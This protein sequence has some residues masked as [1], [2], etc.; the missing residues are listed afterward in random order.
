[1]NSKSNSKTKMIIGNGIVVTRDAKNRVIEQ[2]AIY[3]E[4]SH[5]AAIGATDVIRQQYKDS[6]VTYVDAEGMLIM[7]GYIN[8][9]EHIYSAFAR[10]LSIPGKHPMN[11]LEILNDTWWHMDRHLTLE[12]TYDSAAAT[13]LESIRNGVTFVSDHHAGYGSITGSLE[14]IAR[15]ADELGVRTCLAYEISDR[16]GMEKR[17]ASIREN[18][19]FL[20]QAEK[21]HSSMLKG[22]VGLHAS[23]TLSDE[24][25]EMCREQNTTGAGYH[26]HVAEG[27]Y[28]ETHCQK[29]YGMSVV[30]RLERQGILGTKTVA[31]HCIHISEQDMDILKSTGTTVVHNPESN[32]GNAVGAPDVLTMMDKGIRVGLGTDGYTHDMLESLKVANLLQKHRRGLP[33]RGFT[34]GCNMMFRNN[35]RIASD[36]IEETCGVLE[37]GALADIILVDYKPIT[38]L[39]SDN[40]DGHLMFGVSGAMTDSTIIHGKLLMRHR[41]MLHVDEEKILHACRQSADALW[42]TL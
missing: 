33:D 37:N 29:Q 20:E 9:H 42:K 32:M 22:L 4:D 25:L 16:D 21:K 40:I 24:T 36:L 12:Q 23:F 8:A 10:G 14:Q 1:M 7:P 15:A 31:G 3:I 11:F 30:E 19:H 27:L 26:V 17:D 6:E 39:T 18:M 38:P 5:I 28:D 35:A 34:E 13:Y 2:G 41:K